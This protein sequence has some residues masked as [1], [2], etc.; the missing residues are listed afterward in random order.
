M[1]KRCQKKLFYNTNYCY[2]RITSLVIFDVAGIIATKM[3]RKLCCHS[4]QKSSEGIYGM[5]VV[6]LLVHLHTPCAGPLGRPGDYVKQQQKKILESLLS[7]FNIS[8]ML[9]FHNQSSSLVSEF[10]MQDKEYAQEE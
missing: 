5:K 8:E 9:F 3:S 4:Q 7:L 2:A 10:L 1:K 6:C